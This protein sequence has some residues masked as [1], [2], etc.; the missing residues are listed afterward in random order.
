MV[1]RVSELIPINKTYE[2]DVLRQISP[3]EYK[4]AIR[5]ISNLLRSEFSS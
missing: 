3:G 4:I 1:K 5:E 2:V